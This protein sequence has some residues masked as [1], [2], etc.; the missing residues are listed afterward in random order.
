MNSFDKIFLDLKKYGKHTK[1]RGL[2]VLEIENYN[3]TLKPYERYVS[4]PARK[5]K[6]NYIKQECMWYLKG[7]KYDTSI[8]EHASMWK[9]LINEDG[10]INSNY[11]AYI[12][13]KQN[14]F[15]NVI[16]TLLEDKDSRRA[17]IVILAENHLSS[18]TNDYPC[19]YSINFRIRS[20]KLNMTVR[21][22][23]QDAIFGMTNDAANFSFIHEMVYVTLRDKKYNNLNMGDYYHSADSF[24]IYVKRHGKMFQNI[25]ENIENNLYNEIQ[26]PKIVSLSEVTFLR[27]LHLI[28]DLVDVPDEYK[29]T[30]WLLQR[31]V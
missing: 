15:D 31:E 5:M 6:L 12:F 21:M 2:R 28:S 23:S 7:D 3:Y 4:Y 8:C 16:K 27:N 19:T 22:R 20:N 14:Q 25:I 18:V 13:G 10:S 29:F 17:S 1:P 9:K 24:H 11:G 30:K 26:T